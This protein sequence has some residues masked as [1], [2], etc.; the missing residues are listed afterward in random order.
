MTKVAMFIAGL[1]IALLTGR[2]QAYSVYGYTSSTNTSSCSYGKTYTIT[3]TA[4]DRA[5]G[6]SYVVADLLRPVSDTSELGNIQSTTSLLWNAN[7]AVIHTEPLQD[8]W[9]R[10]WWDTRTFNWSFPQTFTV[11]YTWTGNTYHTLS[12]M[13][14]DYPK[15]SGYYTSYTTNVQYDQD[16]A[17]FAAYA[18][19]TK[20]QNTPKG[21]IGAIERI[22][23]YVEET[24]PG[25]CTTN[26]KLA[27]ALRSIGLPTA[28]CISYIMTPTSVTMPCGLTP[29]TF[30][31]NGNIQD[32]GHL[33]CAIWNDYL[34]RFVPIDKTNL[35]FGFV[36]SPIT[37]VGY[38]EDT[39]DGVSLLYKFND[40]GS[41]ST[42]TMTYSANPSP[43]YSGTPTYTYTGS[44]NPRANN[45]SRI[46]A[47]AIS[48]SYNGGSGI[49]GPPD[50]RTGVDEPNDK[51]DL[52]VFFSNPTSGGHSLWVEM[53][54]PEN[55]SGTIS[56]YDINGR[57]LWSQDVILANTGHANLPIEQ[58]SSGIYFL[59]LRLQSGRSLSKKVVINH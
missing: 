38:F 52:L 49:W 19:S 30:N 44:R 47:E 10:V 31:F 5:H 4:N 56:L 3:V 40:P 54:S 58:V 23:A 8:Q 33:Y 50:D 32:A 55:D 37:T 1:S 39:S 7:P 11:T 24:C 17:T 18:D 16:L 22:M 45:N 20:L 43:S 36:F 25:N 34:S 9:E 15:L 12:G 53:S 42:F 29:A 48:S 27:S 57:Q 59:Q 21:R 41:T 46:F 28:A 26:N 13:K 6:P 14:D 35:S 2:S 51:A